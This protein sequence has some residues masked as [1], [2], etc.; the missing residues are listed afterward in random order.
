MEE[1]EMIALWKAY[2][3][4]LEENLRLNR[5]NAEA[6]TLIK[7]KSL[8]RSMAPYKIFTLVTGILWIAFLVGVLYT[9]YSFASAFFWF[10]IL[11]HVVLLAVV[12]GIYFTQLVLIFQTDITDDLITT[13]GRLAWLKSSTL[14][15]ARLMWVHIPVWMTFCI[16]DQMMKT[17]F[18]LTAHLILT[19]IFFVIAGWLFFNI[20][21][22]NKDKKWFRWIFHG[23]E[24][25][26]VLKSAALLREVEAYSR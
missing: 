25:E 13:Q 8:V 19:L 21:Y 24:W 1:L 20:K 16:S 15:I 2:D 4:K 10:S 23:K 14:L 17:P 26:P 9:T 7:I 18:W 5:Q 11:I 3:Q 22:E 6:I 12:L